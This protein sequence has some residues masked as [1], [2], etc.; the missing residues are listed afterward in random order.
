MEHYK[1]SKLLDD[2]SV[3]KFATK[4]WVEVKNLSGVQYS[5]NNIYC[6]KRNIK[7]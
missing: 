5:V 4:E 2:S 1:I 7:C 6:Y 3:S